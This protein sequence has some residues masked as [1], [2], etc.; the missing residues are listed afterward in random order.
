MLIAVGTEYK[1]W[2]LVLLLASLNSYSY[3]RYLRN[4]ERVSTRERYVEHA[5]RNCSHKTPIMDRVS[6]RKYYHIHKKS[7]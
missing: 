5:L 1:Q 6:S 2:I 7:I 4:I 3:K